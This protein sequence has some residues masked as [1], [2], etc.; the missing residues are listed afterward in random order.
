MRFPT[1]SCFPHPSLL[2]KCRNNLGPFHV[3]PCREGNSKRSRPVI[4]ANYPTLGQKYPWK[5]KM[6]HNNDQKDPS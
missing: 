3:P 5:N 2:Q 4:Y 6:I 1:E